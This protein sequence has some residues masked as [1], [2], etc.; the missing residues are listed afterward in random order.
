M[1]N[2]GKTLNV[3]NGTVQGGE[4]SLTLESLKA[5]ASG[6]AVSYTGYLAGT[7]ATLTGTGE[8]IQVSVYHDTPLDLTELADLGDGTSIFSYL[9]LHPVVGSDDQGQRDVTVTD[10]QYAHLTIWDQKIEE[11]DL[12]I[13]RVVNASDPEEPVELTLNTANSPTGFTLY[14]NVP[15]ST[16]KADG[17]L[18]LYD[19]ISGGDETQWTRGSI[20]TTFD[21]LDLADGTQQN[22][23]HLTAAQL[24]KF[25][26]ITADAPEA[27]TY[28]NLSSDTLTLHDVLNGTQNATPGAATTS[29]EIS[30]GVSK[31]VKIVLAKGDNV[32]T[33]SDN[34]SWIELGST[35]DYGDHQATITLGEGADH[36]MFNRAGKVIFA[37]NKEGV[38]DRIDELGLWVNSS[39][40]TSDFA[41]EARII[42][43][44]ENFGITKALTINGADA[45]AAERLKPLVGV[46]QDLDVSNAIFLWQTDSND[47]QSV[48]EGLFAD[49]NDDAVSK[50]FLTGTNHAIVLAGADV[51]FTGNPESA[52]RS[53]EVSVW[54]VTR[55]QS[56]TEGG[57]YDATLVAT[58]GV[59]SPSDIYAE[60]LGIEFA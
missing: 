51:Y 14:A 12:D 25:T 41:T 45:T 39:D 38:V 24:A 29:Y 10:A 50:F 6:P 49:A 31:D 54:D 36:I 28:G 23:V 2:G 57:A 20:D 44:A 4:N 55:T 27:D 7:G 8:R 48:I 35:G 59:N 47:Q 42:S 43:F 34:G 19:S 11:R 16:I 32:V 18:W 15:G 60:S 30:D 56:D 53:G 52:P 40:S 5:D 1:Q 58:M 3:V 17:N 26:T 46:N 13:V 22:D 37:Q 9:S 33:C 21:H